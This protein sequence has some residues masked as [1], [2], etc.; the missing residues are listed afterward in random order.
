MS[1]Y[2]KDNN[3]QPCKIGVFSIADYAGYHLSASHP[4]HTFTPQNLTLAADAAV[5]PG[6][7]RIIA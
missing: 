3:L 2:R 7:V 1:D 6:R 5:E 4:A